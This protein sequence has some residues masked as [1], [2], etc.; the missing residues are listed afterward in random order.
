M[1]NNTIS[2]CNYLA[3]G[4]GIGTVVGILFAPKSGEE[5]REYVADKIEEGRKYT[6]RNARKLRHRAEDLVERGKQALRLA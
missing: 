2:K 3:V 1:H 5:T 6:R 4:L